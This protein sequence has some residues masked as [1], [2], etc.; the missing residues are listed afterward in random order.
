MNNV[1]HPEESISAI[2]QRNGL[3]L[4]IKHAIARGLGEII[5]R[6]DLPDLIDGVLIEP[7]QVHPDDRG[8]FAEL[9]WPV[10]SAV[11]P[12][13]SFFSRMNIANAVM[14]LFSSQVGPLPQAQIQFKKDP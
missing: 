1:T 8:F 6:L 12:F 3:K 10:S 11:Q 13:M 2:V 4:A 5:S 14:S 9:A 7:L